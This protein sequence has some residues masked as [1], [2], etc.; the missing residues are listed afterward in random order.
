MRGASARLQRVAMFRVWRAERVALALVFVV[1]FSLR[2]WS[3]SKNPVSLNQDEAVNGYDAFCIART[4]RDHHGNFLPIL[5]ES[6]EDWTSPLITYFTVP[7]VT[8]LGLS[9]FSIRLASASAGCSALV[10]MFLLLRSLGL[11]QAAVL[12]GTAML[13]LAPWHIM[14]SRW[15]VPPAIVPATL[16]LTAW[17]ALRTQRED[18]SAWKTWSAFTLAAAVHTYSYPTQKLF[19]PLWIAT[20]V[21]VL[22]FPRW[23]RGLAALSAYALLVSP[24]YWL[25]LRDPRRYNAR[26]N[27]VSLDFDE[28][29]VVW[30]VLRR[31]GEYWLSDF[32]FGRGD[33]D[34]VHRVQEVG[35]MYPVVALLFW[36]GVGVVVAQA[37]GHRLAPIELP[38]RAA[39]VLLA[40]LL[41][42]PIP[43]SL[44]DDRMHLLR[45]V[46]GLPAVLVFAS[47]GLE[48]L[49]RSLAA[50][51][52]QSLTLAMLGG[53]MAVECAVF[54]AQYWGPHRR[55]TRSELQYGMRQVIERALALRKDY[56]EVKVTDDVNQGYI[57]YLFFSQRDPSSLKYDEINR[58]AD[59]SGNWLSVTG[60]DNWEFRAISS[61][62]TADAEKIYEVR[63][64]GRVF[65]RLLAKGSTLYI[66]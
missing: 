42:F 49:L 60:V 37:A 14:L 20:I 4:L 57:L 66:L 65:R 52:V 55:A 9:E 18:A 6:F 11:G 38:R 19:A 64:G 62:E 56:S 43:A 12:S 39:M 21:V 17:L 3:L 61:D 41:I 23:K 27:S 35:A 5:F 1:G 40:W 50:R 13:A 15:A 34:V 8:V 22:S 47:V 58:S 25:A 48:A 33:T 46:H 16:L 29:G 53:V 59:G 45:A 44:T 36:I 51:S 2:L 54:T 30:E 31:Y 32:H 26:F 7:F 24:M 10:F 63:A 28:P